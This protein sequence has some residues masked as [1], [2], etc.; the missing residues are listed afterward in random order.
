MKTSEKN[1]LCIMGCL[2]LI[3]ITALTTLYISTM[4]MSTKEFKQIEK[5]E[6]NVKNEVESY[7]NVWNVSYDL[8]KLSQNLIS[9]EML[10]EKFYLENIPEEF[11][12]AFLYYSRN[13]KGIRPYFY[14]LMRH[15]SSEFTSYYHKN[16]DGSIDKGPSQL[17]TNNIKS[18]TFRDYY[19]PKDESHITSIYCFYMVM[20]MNF[21]WDL[22]NKYGYEYAFY[23]YNGGEK[24]VKLIKN[25]SSQNASLIK[26]V[27]NYD[28]KVRLQLNEAQSNI[29]SYIAEKRA[30]NINELYAFLHDNYNK[31]YNV[32]K[33]AFIVK[34]ENNLQNGNKFTNYDVFYIR[35]EDLLQFEI[36]EGTIIGKTIIGTFNI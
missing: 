33:N 17:N 13:R 16:L 8:T 2:V 32:G 26:A 1:V 12:D 5:E 18:K 28:Y 7:E 21:Y 34:L 22:V 29:T 35:R 36:K 6:V 23:A 14:S 19:N 10:D 24:T 4:K 30:E 3:C 15:E 25:R 11:A 9:D 20:S 27:K 31:S